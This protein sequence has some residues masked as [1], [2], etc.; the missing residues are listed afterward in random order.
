VLVMGVIIGF[1]MMSKTPREKKAELKL[2]E[3]KMNKESDVKVAAQVVCSVRV[4]CSVC[5]AVRVCVA[6]DVLRRRR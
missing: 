6:V 1:V 4:C 3:K 5:V 2:V